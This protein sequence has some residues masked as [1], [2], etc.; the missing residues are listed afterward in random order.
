MSNKP[1]RCPGCSSPR[2]VPIVFG[3]PGHEM[4]EAAERG[5]IE[6]GGCVVTYSDPKWTCVTCGARWGVSTS[7]NYQGMGFYVTSPEE[8]E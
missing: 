8:G 3:Y 2:V 6:L 4:F 5:E 7:E 1:I